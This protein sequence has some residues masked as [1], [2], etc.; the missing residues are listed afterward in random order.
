MFSV[1]IQSPPTKPVYR[2][3]SIRCG[4]LLLGLAFAA[5]G[6]GKSTGKDDNGSSGEDI[7]L[8]VA[9]F[10]AD[11]LI[12]VNIELDPDEWDL[13][14]TEGR[15]LPDVFTNCARDYEYTEFHATVTVD[16]DTYEDVAVRKKGFLGSL[17]TF[18]PSLKL[19]FGRFVEGRTHADMTRMTL[20][21]NLTDPG[22][23][24]Q[25]MAYELFDRAGVIASRCNFAHVVVNGVDLG[26]YT[27][28]ESV[29]KPMLRR[30]FKDDGGNLYEGQIADFS[31]N[32]IDLMELKTNEIENDRSDLA[33]VVEALKASDEDLL[34]ALGLVIDLDAFFTFWAM[35]VITGHWDSYSGNR[36]NYLTY[37][38]PTSD[39]FHFIPWGTD[40]SFQQLRLFNPQNTAVSVL[41]EAAIPNRLYGHAEGRAMYLDR[42]AELFA[43]VWDEA[44]LLAE[45]DRIAL[46]TD[47]PAGPI[48]TQR[49]FIAD[50]GA[51]LIAELGLDPEDA[52]DWIDNPNADAELVCVELGP[53]I[54]GSFN[55]T[56]GSLMTPVNVGQTLNVTINGELVVS[57][58]LLVG[59]GDDSQDP[60]DIAQILFLSP[61]GGG[62]LLGIAI[63]MPK[64]YFTTPGVY[65]MHGFE[66]NAVAVR[67]DLFGGGAFE[68]IGFAGGGT[69]TIEESSLVPGEVVRG[70]FEGDFVQIAP[71]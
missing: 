55:T 44:E 66:A 24:H 59:A 5:L 18:R 37:H 70:S 54:S 45:V 15:S 11:H 31:D 63:R 35:E 8:S 9:L 53:P 47:A 57:P 68:V 29:K 49:A 60:D 40:G 17:S 32:R 46:L 3:Q 69:I 1:S 2:R 10:E 48:A 51:K 67:V 16:E 34:D 30:H 28:V 26:I 25:C 23:T 64:A 7:D 12:E 21:N 33:P 62:I 61:Q 22:N 52:P 6:C 50:Q 20:N 38:D 19:N 13:L 36:N 4:V 56:W 41:A 43:L 71:F 65:P 58:N 39:R 14:R 42:L 27:H